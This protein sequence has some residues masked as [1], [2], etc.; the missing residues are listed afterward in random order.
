MSSDIRK[1]PK[2]NW[3]LVSASPK[4]EIVR[5]QADRG[6]NISLKL[7]E[8]HVYTVPIVPATTVDRI[9]GGKP[10]KREWIGM[11]TGI[12]PA[13]WQ[14]DIEYQSPVEVMFMVIDEEY[15]K[16]V[17]YETI[18]YSPEKFHRVA[19]VQSP[20]GYSLVESIRH[21]ITLENTKEW[22]LLTDHIA[23]S[24]A[25]H[26]MKYFEYSSADHSNPCPRGLPRDRIKRVTEY[27]ESNLNREIYLQEIA[28]IAA[29]SPY[30]F[31]RAFSRSIGI[32]P[33]RY[34]W[35]RRVERAKVLL[36]N[37]DIPLAILA[38]ECGFSSQSH[39]TTV[40]KRETGMTPAQYRAR[41]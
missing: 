13:G 4:L 18:T 16:R 7:S 12:L 26:M 38:L 11:G 8:Q 10:T 25:A 34:V 30:H 29:L 19:N 14:L 9:N 37:K 27:I 1:I 3:L 31:S 15:F 22:P 40:F 20:V 28:D 24:I 36:R 41:L 21:L 5:L 39:F 33:L 23:I 35:R 32:S 6:M 2:A 17:A